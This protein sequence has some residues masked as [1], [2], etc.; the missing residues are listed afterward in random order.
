[1]VE[2]KCDFPLKGYSLPVTEYLGRL[3][4]LLEIFNLLVGEFDV[5]GVLTVGFPRQLS[6][7]NI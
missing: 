3:V 7:L 5:N 1:M 6:Q 2:R 4:W